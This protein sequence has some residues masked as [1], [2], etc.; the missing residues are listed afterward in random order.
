GAG[1]GR[2]EG[3]QRMNGL[4]SHTGLRRRLGVVLFADIANY[5]RLMGDDEVGTIVSVKAR[6]QILYEASAR[7]HG[8]VLRVRGGRSVLLFASA[9]DAV[10]FALEVQ[11]LMAE[12]N[13]AVTPDREVSFRIGINLG[14]I[15]IDGDDVS[16]DSVNIAARIE[17]LAQPGAICVTRAVY[18]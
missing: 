2:S 15:L 5:G 14:E 7:H 4:S 13:A 3:G 6:L 8:D 17:S 11:K 18:D 12:E 16:G 9:V 1:D 10:S